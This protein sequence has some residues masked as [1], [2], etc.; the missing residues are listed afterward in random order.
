MIKLSNSKKKKKRV[1]SVLLTRLR[2]VLAGIADE[3]CAQACMGGVRAEWNANRLLRPA[4]PCFDLPLL[5]TKYYL[6]GIYF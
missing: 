1:N 5:T 3:H 2:K 4:L 6:T